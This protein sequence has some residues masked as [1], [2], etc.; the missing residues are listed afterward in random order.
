MLGAGFVLVKF[1]GIIVPL[2][3]CTA[4]AS[5]D[6]N[7]HIKLSLRFVLSH[8]GLCNYRVRRHAQVREV[9]KRGDALLGTLAQDND[10]AAALANIKNGISDKDK[11]FV[12]DGSSS[13]FATWSVARP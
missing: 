6:N 10:S 2:H 3:G 5:R 11:H 8:L 12:G 9:K 13:S 7:L 4:T 1:R